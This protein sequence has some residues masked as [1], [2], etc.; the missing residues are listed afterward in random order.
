ME[1]LD[2]RLHWASEASR[3]SED[4]VGYTSLLAK[5]LIKESHCFT[6]LL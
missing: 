4:P 3:A 2:F 5:N 1:S 6:I